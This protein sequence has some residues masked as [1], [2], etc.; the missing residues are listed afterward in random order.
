M[1]PLPRGKGRVRRSG[2]QVGNL[3]RRGGTS[4]REQRH[5][6]SALL[7]IGIACG[8]LSV[9][10]IGAGDHQARGDPLAELRDYVQSIAAR[11]D[12]IAADRTEMPR[13]AG[14][15]SDDDPHAALH[16]FV[17]PIPFDPAGSAHGQLRLAEADNA[18]DALR[19]FMRKLNRNAPPEKPGAP[20]P[21]AKASAPSPALNAT[22]VGTKVCLGCHTSQAG[23]FSNTLMGRL[24]VQGKLQCEVCHGP[25]SAHVHAAGCSACHGEGGVTTRPGIPSLAG[26]EAQYLVGALKAYLAVQRKNPLMQAAVS[27]MSEAELDNIAHYYAR[28][29]SA[30]AQT[31]AVGDAAAGK[32]ATG[33]CANC[34]GEQ[35]I[36]VGPAFPNLAGQ[37][38]RYLADAIKAYKDGSRSKTVACAMCH[39]GGGIS[40]R[41]GIP[42]LA[43]VSAQYL[44][45]AL[46][47]YTSGQRKNAVMKALLAGV[48]DS[49]LNSIALYYA[50]Q[51]PARAQTAAVGDPSA[52]KTAI[53]VCAGCH[54]EQG[55]STGPEYPSL[56]G[57]D[58]RY[59][60]E[61][62][63][64]Y[65]EGARS[66]ETMKAMAATVDER[67]INDIA[68]YFASLS[69]AKPAA[70]GNVQGQPAAHEP[71]LVRN[72]FLASLDERTI[73]NIAGYYAG[74]RPAQS[75]SQSSAKSA[76]A[77]REPSQVREA[78]PADRRSLGGIISFRPDDLARAAEENNAICLGCHQRGDRAY[79]DG[80]VHETRGVACTE[81]HTIMKTV[82][83]EHQLKTAF[84]PD[85]CFKC[86][87]D[88]RAQMFR[89][90][91]MPIREGKVVCSDCHNPHGSATEALLKEASINDTC[92][93]CH[94]D[95][96][97]PF[98]FEHEP[99]R[100]NCLGCHNPHG[101][102]NQFSLNISLPRLCYECHTI[103]PHQQTGPSSVYSMSRACLNCHT[104]IHGSNSPAGGA[105]QR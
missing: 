43:G 93:K 57:Q 88:R 77:R 5:R 15:R 37:D 83:A 64:A 48:S 74:L 73:N 30:R 9:A 28:Q 33:L 14:R 89:S 45:S 7:A 36:S 75:Q 25:G 61:A 66:N 68:S 47:A 105:L 6:L 71:A 63:R 76:P 69:P 11:P 29:V 79:W 39:G 12:A 54:G 4:D 86:H 60:A 67:A 20:P 94:A 62:L 24:L 56:A 35:G 92:Y 50:G 80:S 95:K 91:H 99:V 96:R 8:L 65:R 59:I 46:K 70:A 90:S 10:P 84:E 13:L 27:G 87:K 78:V 21:A 100:E 2:P 22:P 58:A 31:P 18:F 19:E 85:T 38:A 49:E 23:V 103:G 52:G 82:S 97:G 53:A 72:G 40:T 1:S 51:N 55:I 101:S 32:S 17:H 102:I 44:V 104:Q 26:Q 3:I 98:L 42:S 34:H 81:C 16:G 41:P